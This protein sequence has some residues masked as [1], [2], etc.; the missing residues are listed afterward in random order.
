VLRWGPPGP[1]GVSMEGLDALASVQARIAEIQ[2]RFNMP[3]PQS[4]VAVAPRSA[5]GADFSSVL[6]SAQGSSGSTMAG[7][8]AINSSPTSGDTRSTAARTQFAGDLLD[9]MGLPKT[10]ENVRAIV[11]WA[12]A[13][14]TKASFNPLA[15]TT[16]AANTTNFNSVGVKNYANYA[17]G[18]DATVRTLRN[19]NYPNILAALAS[20]TSAQAVA[21]AVANSPWG[22]GQGVL[23]V[24]AAGTV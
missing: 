23:R 20:G 21:Q 12:T 6:A 4:S 13:E 22:T 14:G 15:T 18:L 17:D 11:A 1:N 9:R 2:A 3:L 24:L 7:S 19:G 5:S 16:K 8:S 10:S